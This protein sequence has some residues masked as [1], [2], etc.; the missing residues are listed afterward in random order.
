MV[1]FDARLASAVDAVQ[2]AGLW[3]RILK[4]GGSSA[5]VLSQPEPSIRQVSHARSQ[6]L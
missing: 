5:D 3:E 1:E 2:H 4:S 6:S